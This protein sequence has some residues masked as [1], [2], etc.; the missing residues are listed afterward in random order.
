M[1]RAKQERKAF[2]RIQSSQTI[3]VTCGLQNKDVTNPDAHVPE[4]LKINPLWPKCTV[5][6]KEGAHWYPS[7]IV[8]WPTVKTLQDEDILTI[9][10]FSDEPNE[11]SKDIQAEKKMVQNQMERIN[12]EIGG[13]L[14]DLANE[15][16]E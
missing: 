1:G 12:K 8:D 5:L 6:I 9:G 11:T 14:A 7:E 10:E 2:V 4:R 13:S 15:E 16:G 3:N